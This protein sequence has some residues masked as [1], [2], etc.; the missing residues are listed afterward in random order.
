[1]CGAWYKTL[2]NQQ[3]AV[4]AL[5]VVGVQG[6]DIDLDMELYTVVSDYGRCRCMVSLG[7]PGP[8]DPVWTLQGLFLKK[9]VL[10]LHVKGGGKGICRQGDQ[11]GQGQDGVCVRLQKHASSGWWERPLNGGTLFSVGVILKNMLG[12]E[13]GAGGQ[14]KH[15]G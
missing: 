3:V 10:E 4:L 2:R 5:K 1:M 12:Q 15:G 11:H 13:M 7:D 14:S 6:R 8:C 9:A